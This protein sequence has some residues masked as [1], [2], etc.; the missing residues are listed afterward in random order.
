M[1]EEI[2]ALEVVLDHPDAFRS[3]VDRLPDPRAVLGLKAWGRRRGLYL[4]DH[5]ATPEQ[6]TPPTDQPTL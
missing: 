1:D 5:H 3:L 2:R 6:S 4:A